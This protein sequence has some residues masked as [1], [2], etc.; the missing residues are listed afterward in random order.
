MSEKPLMSVCN[1][2]EDFFHTDKAIKYDG[3]TT[4]KV[5]IFTVTW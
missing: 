2:V 3:T 5:G 1:W 4:E